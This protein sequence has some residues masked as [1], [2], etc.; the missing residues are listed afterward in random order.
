M[1][2]T[3]TYGVYIPF[4][5]T[6]ADAQAFDKVEEVG[7]LPVDKDSDFRE[8]SEEKAVLRARVSDYDLFGCG[9][10]D[11]DSGEVWLF[12]CMTED[13]MG[14]MDRELKILKEGKIV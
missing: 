12:G 14:E 10:K 9:W 2:R 4:K 6:I 5:K 1:V 8:I 11:E 13:K 7:W 3:Y